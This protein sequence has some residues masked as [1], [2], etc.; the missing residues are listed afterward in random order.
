MIMN[1]LRN[2]VFKMQKQDPGARF[3]VA[4]RRIRRMARLMVRMPTKP[5]HAKRS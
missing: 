4:V 1:R 3:G 5:K 2:I